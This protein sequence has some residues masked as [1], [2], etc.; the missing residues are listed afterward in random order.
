VNKK[1]ATIIAIVIVNIILVG[2]AVT[3]YFTVFQRNNQV[4]EGKIIIT[5]LVDQQINLTLV[6][7]ELMPNITK[8]Y[9]LNGNPTIIAD[10]TGV[11]LGYLLVEVANITENYK[12]RIIAIDNYPPVSLSM[13]EIITT[14]DIIIAYMKDGE[15]IKSRTEGGNGPFRLIIP[16]RYP[17]EWNGQLCMKYVVEIN[18]YE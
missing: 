1:T 10:Y 8:E 2:T 15:Y 17:G 7:L 4:E 11:S 16:E 14:P 3:L 6:D 5:G 12:V 9:T 18:I 13:V